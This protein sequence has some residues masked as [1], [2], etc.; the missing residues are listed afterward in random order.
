MSP[1]TEAKRSAEMTLNAEKARHFKASRHK[2]IV[3]PFFLD[4]LTAGMPSNK[5]A[6]TAT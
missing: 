4:S 2:G 6:K 5:P 1:S 3:I